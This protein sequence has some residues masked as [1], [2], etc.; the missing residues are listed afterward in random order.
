MA[1][2]QD[3]DEVYAVPSG[4][5]HVSPEQ[6][7]AINAGGKL[8]FSESIV[9]RCVNHFT[10]DVRRNNNLQ[11][12]GKDF[13]GIYTLQ[14]EMVLDADRIKGMFTLNLSESDRNLLSCEF[15]N[16]TRCKFHLLC[17]SVYYCLL[18]FPVVF[19]AYIQ[20]AGS[21]EAQG[22]PDCPAEPHLQVA[23]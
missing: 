5:F 21:K 8:P 7:E 12:L 15:P 13:R 17:V 19:S 1:E 2:S 3:H 20:T 23:C 6:L 10:E 11:A 9:N 18:C 22:L 4:E 16:P 14:T